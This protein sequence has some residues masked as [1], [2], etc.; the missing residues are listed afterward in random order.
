M[1]K[2]FIDRNSVVLLCDFMYSAN[3][4][5]VMY[6]YLPLFLKKNICEFTLFTSPDRFLEIKYFRLKILICYR[7]HIIVILYHLLGCVICFL[8]F[9]QNRLQVVI[10]DTFS[11]PKICH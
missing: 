11:T 8:N 7:Q 4:L 5:N 3:N 1:N 2:S 6:F 10:F 9:V